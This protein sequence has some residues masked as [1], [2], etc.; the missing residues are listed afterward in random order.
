MPGL[1]SRD[2]RRT[3]RRSP[4]GGD[5][6]TAVTSGGHNPSAPTRSS[7]RPAGNPQV[8]ARII[9]IA[10]LATFAVV[11][12]YLHLSPDSDFNVGGYNV[13]HLFTGVLVLVVCA[14]PLALDPRDTAVTR[15]SA[16]GFGLGLSLTLDEW[17]Y[18]IVTDGSNASYLLPV[19]WIGGA[20]LNATAATYILVLGRRRE[21]DA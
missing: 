20:L 13:H 11:R 4:R 7:G 2:W 17:V 5:S 10:L 16:M 14:V 15:V 18:L 21:P 6:F 19:S 8:R 12:T 3:S 9:A 1:S